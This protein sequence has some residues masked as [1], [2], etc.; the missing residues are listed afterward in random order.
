MIPFELSR[1]WLVEQYEKNKLSAIQISEIIGCTRHIIYYAMKKYGIKKRSLSEAQQNRGSKFTLLN[2]RDWLFDE[3]ITKNLKCKEIAIKAGILSGKEDAVIRALLKFRIKTRTKSETRLLNREDCG[4]FE[5][6][7]FIDGS[8]LGDGS[9]EKV[10]S[11]HISETARF[12]KKSKS[13]LYL[14]WNSQF[15]FK[16]KGNDRITYEKTILNGKSFK[17]YRMRSLH[18][19]ELIG[20]MRRWYIGHPPIKIVPKDIVITPFLLLVWFMDDG[21]SHFTKKE[22]VRIFLSSMC[23]NKKDQQFLCDELMRLYSIKTSLNKVKS[24]TGYI[25]RINKKSISIFYN[26]IG[27]CPEP[28]KKVFGYKWK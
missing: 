16:N 3:Y 19:N 22:G 24:G 20:Y 23:F 28:L 11:K 1:D 14:L 21:Y 15:M 2:N 7:E 5:N 12:S 13:Y 27:P 9:L 17:T 10:N 4:F 6:K 26:T 18:H 25:I 8:L